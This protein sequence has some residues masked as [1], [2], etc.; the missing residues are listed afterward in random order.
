MRTH[1]SDRQPCGGRAVPLRAGVSQPNVATRGTEV[2][3]VLWESRICLV[4][5]AFGQHRT[6]ACL[7]AGQ[8]ANAAMRQ[9]INIEVTCGTIFTRHARPLTV[10]FVVVFFV[11]GTPRCVVGG[12]LLLRVCN[13]DAQR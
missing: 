8:S 3:G 2:A 12:C 7:T 1:A 4:A 10:E 6:R 11:A 9:P 13:I 5:V